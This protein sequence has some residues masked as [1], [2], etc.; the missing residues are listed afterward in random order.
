[1]SADPSFPWSQVR[2]QPAP[3]SR[4][5]PAPPRSPGVS[6]PVVVLLLAAQLAIVLGAQVGYRYWFD[7]PYTPRVVEA[8]GDLAADEQSTIKLYNALR[9]SV[10]HV[11]TLGDD[12]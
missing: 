10:V 4:R 6:W 3:E 2:P 5:Y 11:T 8:R 1:M 9:P 12:D 7:R